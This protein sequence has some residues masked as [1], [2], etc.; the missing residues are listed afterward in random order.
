[1]SSADH[2]HGHAVEKSGGG[3]GFE[4]KDLFGFPYLVKFFRKTI[5]GAKELRKSLEDF[6][7]MAVSYSAD[8]ID[9]TIAEIASRF[10]S[11]GTLAFGGGAKPA[12]AGAH[13]H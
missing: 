3:E 10:A 12:S 13:G 7:K 6:T 8:F 2:G 5:V 1:M 11:F 4:F 9:G